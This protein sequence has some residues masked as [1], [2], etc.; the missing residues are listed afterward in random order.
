MISLQNQK[1]MREEETAVIQCRIIE[2]QSQLT[3]WTSIAD[4]EASIVTDLQDKI[5]LQKSR[6]EQNE[7]VIATLQEV[8]TKQS[9][10]T[11]PEKVIEEHLTA[12]STISELC[13]SGL[14][15]KIAELTAVTVERQVDIK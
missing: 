8:L 12:L 13:G 7:I 3:E 15:S 6:H 2:L 14:K 4:A 1:A 10:E 9:D 5:T 11:L